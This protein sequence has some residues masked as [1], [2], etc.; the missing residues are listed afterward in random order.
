MQLQ[1]GARY[2]ERVSPLKT[3]GELYDTLLGGQAAAAAET[4]GPVVAMDFEDLNGEEAMPVASEGA[5]AEWNGVG[6][7]AAVV[8]VGGSRGDR[9]SCYPAS[10]APHTPS[11]ATKNRAT[12]D[13]RRDDRGTTS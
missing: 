4:A 9:T 8:G 13:A 1:S 3:L 10:H 5:C 6:G 11:H 12:R 7:R 2:A